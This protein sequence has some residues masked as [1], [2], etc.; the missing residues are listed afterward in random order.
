MYNTKNA[1]NSRITQ[2]KIMFVLHFFL[3][4]TLKLDF[5]WLYFDWKILLQGI[6]SHRKFVLFYGSLFKNLNRPHSD[7]LFEIIYFIKRQKIIDKNYK[8]RF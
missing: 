4:E 7:N 3:Y 1:E 5:L 6:F 2:S 8:F